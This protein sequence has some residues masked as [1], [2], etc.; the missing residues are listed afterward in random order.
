MLERLGQKNIQLSTRNGTWALSSACCSLNYNLIG[1]I[2]FDLM[3][4]RPRTHLGAKGL[5][6]VAAT[7]AACWLASTAAAVKATNTTINAL[8]IHTKAWLAYTSYGFILCE[9][10]LG[11]KSDR[12]DSFIEWLNCY[13]KGP[14]F[15][16]MI[17][18]WSTIET[19]FSLHFTM[20]SRHS[21][22][23]CPAC[24][25]C[26]NAFEFSETWSILDKFSELSIVH[27]QKIKF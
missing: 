19:L 17:K 9:K 5:M 13:P 1:L 14:M 27:L 16:S 2:H 7:A 11:G 24:K 12:D 25:Q 23:Y 6:T 10:V 8:S 15:I 4:T 26:P 18:C 20:H 22:S 3:R 21:H